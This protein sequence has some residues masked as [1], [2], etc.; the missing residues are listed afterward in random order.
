MYTPKPLEWNI[1]LSTGDESLD[2]QHRYLVDL[3]NK[4]GEAIN[5]G[6]GSESLARILGALRFYAGWH[7]GK[8]ED[9]FETYHCPAAGK[10]KKAHAVFI[11]KF[12]TFNNEFNRIGGSNELALMI[13]E[14]ISDWI[15][16]HILI[17]DGE[18][19]PCIHKKPKPLPKAPGL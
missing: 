4:L 17:V 1:A 8:E 11:E 16:N 10:N 2:N 7:F 3:L 13:H 5:E 14:E 12:D 18:L 9:C 15:I 19:Y 6:H